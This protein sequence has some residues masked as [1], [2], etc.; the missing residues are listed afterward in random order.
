M[1][2]PPIGQTAPCERNFLVLT[3]FRRVLTLVIS[4]KDQDHLV[5]IGV[6][7]RPQQQISFPETEFEE[8]AAELATER[9]STYADTQFLKNLA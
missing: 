1:S 5:A 7:K 4:G 3:F 8:A 9:R 2:L 6:A